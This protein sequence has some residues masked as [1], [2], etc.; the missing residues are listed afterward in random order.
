MFKLP[1]WVLG[2]GIEYACVCM[3]CNEVKGMR[4]RF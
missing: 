4:A 1:G 3:T 2:I